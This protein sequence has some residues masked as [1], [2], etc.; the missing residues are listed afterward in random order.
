MIRIQSKILI[1]VLFL[2]SI[3]TAIPVQAADNTVTLTSTAGDLPL[4]VSHPRLDAA[5]ALVGADWTIENGFTGKG[6]SVA[7]IDSGIQGDHVQFSGRI[8]KQVCHAHVEPYSRCADKKLFDDSSS[9]A[10]YSKNPN[11]LPL[12][13]SAFHGTA[14]ASSI[15]EFAPD[16]RLII[17]KNEYS[18]GVFKNLEWV[19]ENA[20]KYNIVAVNMSFGNPYQGAPGWPRN[21]GPCED[22]QMADDYA[23]PIAKLRQLGV[24]SIVA[25]MNNWNINGMSSPACLKD[26]VSV[27][28]INSNGLVADYSNISE[29]LTLAAPTEFETANVADSAGQK[30]NWV[31]SFSG[32]SAATPVVA[33]LFAIGKSIRPDASVS[34][35]IRIARETAIDIEDVIVKDVKL[36]QFDS[37]V[38]MMLNDATFEQIAKIT[39]ADAKAAADADAKAAAELKAKQEADAKAAAELKAKQEADAK[40]A[41]DKIVADA[42]V[43]AAKILADAKA[44]A[45]SLTKKTSITCIK[46][47]LIKKVTGINPKCPTGYKVKR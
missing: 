17:L 24:A 37:F 22:T 9:S 18:N 29:S 36:I 34:T 47:K 7:V 12:D 1:L 42:K 10:E 21:L 30:D 6:V 45:N 41:A 26:S 20:K 8:L 15:L 46:G 3:F 35:L 25:S 31:E 27:G 38:R 19:I 28:A 14:V 32:T 16:V 2:V 5:R 39:D 11:G 44:K 40:A 13:G 23:I 33:A 43:E 4:P